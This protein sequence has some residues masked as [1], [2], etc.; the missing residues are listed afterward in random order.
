VAKL[1][2]QTGLIPLYE[3]ENGVVTSVRKIAKK[4]PVEEYLKLQGRFRHLFKK[5]GFEKELERI[6]AM[7]DATI[8]KVNLM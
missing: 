4:L 7:A 6:Q 3:M 2:V 1:A 8:K 5:P